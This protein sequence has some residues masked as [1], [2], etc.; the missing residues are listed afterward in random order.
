MLK[1]ICREKSSIQRSLDLCESLTIQI[2]YN[3]SVYSWSLACRRLYF[4]NCVGFFVLTLFSFTQLSFYAIIHTSLHTYYEIIKRASSWPSKYSIS[5]CFYNILLD[6][7]LEKIKESSVQLSNTTLIYSLRRSC[8]LFLV[9]V[10][11]FNFI[12]NIL[13]LLYIYIGIPAR[14]P[15]LPYFYPSLW[16]P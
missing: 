12:I 6:A 9:V 4:V 16:V 3:C 2:N 10:C 8:E 15:H 1:Q 11:I 13:W 5:F 7:E 14:V